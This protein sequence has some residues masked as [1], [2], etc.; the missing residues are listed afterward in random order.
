M[1]ENYNINVNISHYN[2]LPNNVS[3]NTIFNCLYLN[4][5][6]LRNSIDDIQNFVDSSN[7]I[8]HVICIAETW[9]KTHDISFFNLPG[10]ESFHSVRKDKNGGGVAIFL[11]NSFDT[12]SI[13][14][15]D[16]LLNNNLLVIS[17]QRNKF[18]LGICYRQPGNPSDANGRLFLEKLEMILNR[19]KCSYF[20]GDFN[21]NL[22]A[23]TLLSEEYQ[24][25]IEMNGFAILNSTSNDFP[26]RISAFHN[27]RSCIDHCLTDSHYYDETLSHKLCL[28]DLIGDH[29][30][31]FLNIMKLPDKSKANVKPTIKITNHN[32]I[33]NLKLIEAIDT[34]CFT[35]YLQKLAAIISDNSRTLELKETCKKPYINKRILNLARIR[36][37]YQKLYAKYPH[38]VYA[39][40]KLKQYRNLVKK[41]IK[42]AKKQFCKANFEKNL[43]NPRKTWQLINSLLYNKSPS[44]TQVCP[45]LN[46][47]GII[48]SD[49]KNKANHLNQFFIN[50]GLDS[51]RR[52]IV[53]LSAQTA[54]LAQESYNISHNF[55]CPQ[56]TEDEIKLII[57][58]LKSS[59]AVDL[60]GISNNFLKVHQKSLIPQIN[61]LINKY[62]FL[63]EFPDVLKVGV[64]H[65]VYK[66]GPKTDMSNY[67]PISM[68]PIIGKVFEYVIYRRLNDHLQLNSV[69]HPN[70][71][72][73][74][75]KSNT[76]VALLHILNEV[77]NSV[78]DG[79]ATSL[80]C[81]DLSK[82]F[83]SLNHDI[84]LGKV[85]KLGLERFFCNLVCS[86]LVD[87]QQVVQI[88]GIF[89]DFKD[90]CTG[91]PQGG[92]L[93]GLLFNIYVN[94]IFSC[95]LS[96]F[97]AL[98]CDDMS[99]VNSAATH[100]DLKG[101]IEED[102]E[103][104]NRW[105]KYHFLSPN[106]KKS[107]YLLFHN[108]KRFENFID[109]SLSI[110]LD[111]QR[112]ERVENVRLLG[113]ILDETLSFK[114]YI[115]SLQK[116]LVPLMFAI[117]R[118]RHLISDEVA[119]MLYFAY[120]HSNF[121]YLS[122]IWSVT[123]QYLMNRMEVLQRK[124]L[125]IVLRKDWYCSYK[126][127][128]SETIF[129]ISVSARLASYMHVHKITGNAV[130]N[131]IQV[132]AAEQ[133]HSHN[134][135]NR[136]NFII[137]HCSTVFGANNFY[138]RAFNLYNELPNEIKAIHSLS[139]FRNRTK[140]HL[141]EDVVMR[142]YL[143]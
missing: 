34:N 10:Y 96:G 80:T 98:Y 61:K 117:K 83:D 110:Q 134:T 36:N 109:G 86:Y 75:P 142:K 115:D 9:L 13:L 43:H 78:D 104:V 79:L 60:F 137:Q 62:M 2:A 58:N 116:K 15:E 38:F 55:I 47:N 63:G 64:V 113:L 6:S 53:D 70:Q 66:A 99:L 14:F 40:E 68:L 136:S 94:S 121:V 74:C 126:E 135:R 22:F 91:T 125:R 56:S 69:L 17:L 73:F 103:T 3:T 39:H 59:H 93:S 111:G 139:I 72:G 97:L 82:A 44:A 140:E 45:T 49:N 122:T 7:I 130:K 71:F 65:P 101:Q 26:T 85:R 19:F 88:G 8:F 102:L 89:G 114:P 100:N 123:P 50:A 12:G 20:F 28:F 112:I 92:V 133:R 131:N 138:V 32:R 128:Y 41:S 118:I 67:R 16:D 35:V 1:N 23:Q 33:T 52:N 87:R 48:V 90:V 120:F 31:L 107:N 29:K 119:M 4:A 51:S 30:S 105:L 127:L 42:V 24:R 11:L 5:Q 132:L 124:A 57:S 129:P 46:C 27:S 95:N 108:R 84:L 25:I 76:E 81:V 37:Q 18:N 106:S 21:I 143:N 77:Y 141:F 54:F